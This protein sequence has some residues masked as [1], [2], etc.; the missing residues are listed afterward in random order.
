MGMP[1][2]FYRWYYRAH[3]LK[4]LERNILTFC[5]VRPVHDIVIG[6]VEGMSRAKRKS[7]LARMNELGR[8][9]Q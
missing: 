9:A 4:S 7:W 6:V 8:K 1:A 5:G 2:L 3:S